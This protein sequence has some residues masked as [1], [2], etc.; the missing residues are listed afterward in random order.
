MT[1]SIFSQKEIEYLNS[2]RL[3]RI[4][5]AAV[6][7]H[8]ERSVQPDVVPVGFDF[9][10]DYFYVGGMNILKSIKYKNILKNNRVAIVIDDLKTV[11]PWDPRGIKIYGTADVTTRQNGY[12]K[13]TDHPNPQYIRISPKR[14]WS[15]GIEEPV[16][17]EGKFNVKRAQ[18]L[19][20]NTKD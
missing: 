19:E 15:W 11:N 1:N 14:K 20:F 17:V 16:F 13:N 6:S 8:E 4:A 9:D 5:T 3:A 10:G 18:A 2:Q 12:M 7:T